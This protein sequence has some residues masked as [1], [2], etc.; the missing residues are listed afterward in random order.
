MAFVLKKDNAV[1][2][3]VTINMAADGGK[4]EDI[5]AS[6]KFRIPYADEYEEFKTHTDIE[7]LSTV[8]VDLG[9]EFKEEDGTPLKCSQQ[10]KVRLFKS[11]LDVRKGFA[12][13]FQQIINGEAVEKN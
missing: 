8:V 10:N 7:F 1:W 12:K 2:W 13:A 5:V 3:P 4:R 11:S 9:E 6:A